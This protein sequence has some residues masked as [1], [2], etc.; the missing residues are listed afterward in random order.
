MREESV[1]LDLIHYYVRTTND[2]IGEDGKY[3]KGGYA[4]VSKETGIVEGTS[5]NRPNAMI[6]AMQCDA[7]L[8]DLLREDSDDDLIGEFT[9]DPAPLEH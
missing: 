5:M 4:M 2:A 9:E 6:M 3:G 7:M 1:I 8:E